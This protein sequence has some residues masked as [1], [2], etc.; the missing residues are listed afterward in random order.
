MSMYYAIT[1]GFVNYGA[2]YYKA[3]LLNEIDKHDEDD[4]ERPLYYYEEEIAA[5]WLY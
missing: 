2:K 5:L 4:S 1:I 3:D